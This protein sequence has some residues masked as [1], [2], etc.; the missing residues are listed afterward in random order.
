[1]S[2]A[3]SKTS[4]RSAPRTIWGRCR[5]CFGV[6]DPADSGGGSRRAARGGIP[7]TGLS[8]WWSMP[9]QRH[10]PQ[11]LQPGQHGA[12]RSATRSWCWPTAICGSRPT[13]SAVSWLRCSSP[14]IGARRP[15]SITASP[16]SGL[17]PRLSAPARS[18]RTSCR[19]CSSA[20]AW[21]CARPVL[22]LDHRAAARDAASDRRVRGLRRPP[23]RRLRDRRGGARRRARGRDPA[24]HRSA[25]SA[26]SARRASCC[27][28]SCAGRARS[29]ASIRPATRA[30]AITHPFPLAL[31]R[32]RSPGA[33][34]ASGV[35][36][37]GAIACRIALACA[38]E[39]AL[40]L[41]RQP[42]WLVPAARPA[43]VRGVRCEPL[44]RRA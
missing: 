41:R 11:G 19:T 17:W 20:S 9:G 16:A 3:C 26:P 30:S 28:T 29:A 12:R 25:M 37:R 32:P 38:I 1:M 39:R 34:G 13:I 40:A 6:Q 14:G 7:A 36:R 33:P 42:Y 43:V 5:S 15:A 8:T 23:R 27:G 18:T 21:A 4:P 35:A 2:R 22:R 10:E 44:R 31:L 24:A